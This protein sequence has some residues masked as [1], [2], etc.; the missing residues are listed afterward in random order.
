MTAEVAKEGRKTEAAL[1]VAPSVI[2][3]YNKLIVVVPRYEHLPT[4][5]PMANKV[6]FSKTETKRQYR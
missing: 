1:G 4:K 3:S 6:S 5:T 2:V